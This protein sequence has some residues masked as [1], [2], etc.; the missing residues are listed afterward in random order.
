MREIRTLPV[1]CFKIQID[2]L[3]VCVDHVSLLFLFR[4]VSDMAQGGILK[5]LF[6]GLYWEQ[7]T[8]QPYLSNA[9]VIFFQKHI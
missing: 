9:N 6:A 3:C 4:S 1:R 5:I 7:I 8:I 2:P